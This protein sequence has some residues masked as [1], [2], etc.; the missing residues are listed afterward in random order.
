V[1]R[2][3]RGFALLFADVDGFRQYNLARGYAEGDTLLRECARLLAVPEV[4]PVVRTAVPLD[5]V[6]RYGSNRF[7]LLMPQTEQARALD[8]AERI[9]AGVERLELPGRARVTMSV[10][11]VLFPDH[12]AS[13]QD[14]IQAGERALRDAKAAGGN[15]VVVAAPE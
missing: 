15:R 9:R 12:G 10:S 14:L 3:T 8:T 11:V 13:E 4:T 6:A 5:I 7:S 1:R 2:R